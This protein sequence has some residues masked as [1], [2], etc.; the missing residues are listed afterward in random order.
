[1]RGTFCKQKHYV[2]IVLFIFLIILSLVSCMKLHNLQPAGVNK[3]YGIVRFSYK[4]GQFGFNKKK[5]KHKNDAKQKAIER[6]QDLGYE[7]AEYFDTMH[8]CAARNQFGTCIFY[9]VILRY[10]C[11]E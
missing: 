11:V 6:C 1:M 10:E 2:F 3:D 5:E 9:K 8:E 4:V 7:S